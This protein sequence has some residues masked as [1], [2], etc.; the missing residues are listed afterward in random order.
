MEELFNKIPLTG[1][2]KEAFD[3]VVEENGIDEGKS[4]LREVAGMLQLLTEL[5]KLPLQAKIDQLK[6]ELTQATSEASKYKIQVNAL[7]E[8]VE[9]LTKEND[10]LRISVS[11]LKQ[12]A[13]AS[14]KLVDVNP[15]SVADELFRHLNR[16]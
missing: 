4:Q 10:Q 16:F 3:E 14:D 11:T 15:Q 9:R 8:E 5:E 12:V 7:E 6:K 1:K 13:I 2:F